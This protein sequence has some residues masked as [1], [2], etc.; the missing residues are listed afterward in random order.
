MPGFVPGELK[1]AASAPPVSYTH[2]DVYKRQVLELGIED[3]SDLAAHPLD[4]A[5]AVEDREQGR[6]APPEK[7]I[8]I[9]QLL[10]DHPGEF[11]ENLVAHLPAKF[12][13][14][15]LQTI[16]HKHD[17]EGGD[18]RLTGFGQRGFSLGPACQPGDGILSLIH[19]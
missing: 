5:P 2:L 16:E 18:I 19:I 7:L 1:F 4:T 8:A 14:Q 10:L 15:G 11:S 3:L 12:Q 9:W 17:G 13:V 6:S